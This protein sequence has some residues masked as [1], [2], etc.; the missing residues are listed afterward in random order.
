MLDAVAAL[1]EKEVEREVGAAER[2]TQI[3]AN[4]E[5]RMSRSVVSEFDTGLALG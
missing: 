1:I 4:R 3:S 2:R 5:P